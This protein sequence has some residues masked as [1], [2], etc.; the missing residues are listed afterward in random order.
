MVVLFISN[1]TLFGAACGNQTRFSW[2][3]AKGADT[4]PASDDWGDWA[5]EPE[6]PAT[7]DW[8]DWDVA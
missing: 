7:D 5:A 6:K 2:L 8:S 1:P 3:E 4:A